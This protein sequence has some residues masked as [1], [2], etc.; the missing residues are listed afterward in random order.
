MKIKGK[1]IVTTRIAQEI[2]VLAMGLLALNIMNS[3]LSLVTAGDIF[4]RSTLGLKEYL[5]HQFMVI[6]ARSF[7]NLLVD[8]Y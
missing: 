2:L 3:H 1:E 4:L 6:P 5:S 7:Q 8:V